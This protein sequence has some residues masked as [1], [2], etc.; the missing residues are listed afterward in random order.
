M[1]FVKLKNAYLKYWSTESR[2]VHRKSFRFH[3]LNLNYCTFLWVFF[4]RIRENFTHLETSPFPVKGCK[5]ATTAVMYFLKSLKSTMKV[6]FYLYIST[7][8][9]SILVLHLSWE[10]LY[11]LIFSFKRYNDI[12]RTQSDPDRDET[13]VECHKSL[14]LHSL[15]R[16]KQFSEK[17]TITHEFNTVFPN[18]NK[19]WEKC[20]GTFL[21]F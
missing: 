18:K 21:T 13:F 4:C 6:L 8:G 10:K 11:N 9:R 14:S 17:K 7:Y 20:H 5:W 1:I 19:L 2:A 16:D 15:Q 3:P 12:P